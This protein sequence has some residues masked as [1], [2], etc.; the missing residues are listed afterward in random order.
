MAASLYRFVVRFSVCLFFLIRS[1]GIHTCQSRWKMLGKD[2]KWEK[3][4]K[5]NEW[6]AFEE[7]YF[8]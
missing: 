8:R 5:E 4:V 6:L 7:G 3:K 1:K 2:K